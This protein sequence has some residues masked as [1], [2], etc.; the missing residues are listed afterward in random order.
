MNTK[1]QCFF[2]MSLRAVAAPTHMKSHGGGAIANAASEVGLAGKPTGG[3]YSSSEDGVIGFTR[4]AAG[5]YANMGIRINAVASGAVA[6]PMI[7]RQHQAA[8]DALMALQP[9][10]R[11]GT[12]KKLP[13]RSS[14][15]SCISSS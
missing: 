7:L 6:T 8:Q 14:G 13:G 10:H 12:L 5:E 4:S 2:G 9:M 11:L 1:V 15:W 3:V